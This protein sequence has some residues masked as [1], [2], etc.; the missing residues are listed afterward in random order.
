[1]AA[2]GT[3][4]VLQGF[5]ML[6]QNDLRRLDGVGGELPEGDRLWLPVTRGG[7]DTDTY[8]YLFRSTT[9]QPEEVTLSLFDASGNQLDQGSRT[10]N[11]PGFLSAAI[12]DLFPVATIPTRGSLSVTAPEGVRALAVFS[13]R[14]ALG[15]L[16]LTEARPVTSLSAP[17]FFVGR[18]AGSELSL[19]NV[20][21]HPVTAR[22]LAFDDMGETLA[23]TETT[24][25]AGGLVSG[26]LGAMLSLEASDDQ[27][28]TGHL[29]I[30]VLPEGDVENR[31]LG[32]IA[33]GSNSGSY[34]SVLPLIPEGR[35]D[36]LILQI[37]QSRELKIFTGLVL[38]NPGT[39][40]ADTEIRVFKPNGSLAAEKKLNLEAG[41]RIVD[42]LNGPAFFGPG[43]TQVGGHI[44][45]TASQPVVTFA[46]F[47][48]NDLRY[49][50]AIESQRPLAEFDVL[51]TNRGNCG[52]GSNRGPS[53][54]RVRPDPRQSGILEFPG[55]STA[56]LQIMFW[57]NSQK[58]SSLGG[59]RQGLADVT[60]D[61]SPLTDL[62]IEASTSLA[63]GAF[64]YAATSSL[65]FDVPEGLRRYV[66]LE[67]TAVDVDECPTTI[68]LPI[69]LGDAP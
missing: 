27:L 36:N 31:V 64:P 21:S 14:D 24:L 20:E 8:L 43:F 37:A 38:L 65:S 39:E 7:P 32:A 23:E 61:L 3:L 4:G 52:G 46:M 58:M 51:E 56:H 10:L 1:M 67:I 63:V 28:L 45:I 22:I 48:D 66:T 54:V 60:W 29:R 5:F 59:Y 13:D 34:L 40:A 68:R 17:Q 30:E 11:A 62:G 57:D 41:R 50:S 19:L 44:E 2:R 49:L 25:P 53:I 12:H 15:A 47:G 26:D 9:A 16:S 35:R 6:G 55:G 33:F 18:D 42:V 69:L